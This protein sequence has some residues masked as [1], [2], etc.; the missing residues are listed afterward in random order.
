MKKTIVTLVMVLV[1]VPAACGGGGDGGDSDIPIVYD[2]EIDVSNLLS[3]DKDRI[4]ML[5]EFLSALEHSDYEAA[6]DFMTPEGSKK[7][8]ESQTNMT[9]FFEEFDDA[10]ITDIAVQF[11]HYDFITYGVWLSNGEYERSKMYYAQDEARGLK[12]ERW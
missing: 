8:A 10:H 4:D 9:D 5:V 1:L 3:R 11:I 6:K 7:L 2:E 12:I